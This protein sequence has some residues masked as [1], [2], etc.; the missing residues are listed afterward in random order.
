MSWSSGAWQQAEPAGIPAPMPDALFRLDG[1]RWIPH[2]LTR[3]PWAPNAMHGGPVAALMAHVLERVEAPLP[4]FP[5]RLT[6][7]L[8]RPVPIVP[9]SVETRIVRPGKKVQWAEARLAADGAEVARATLLR[10]RDAEIPWPSR[11]AGGDTAL[12]FAGP[13]SS[14][15]VRP[16]WTND[17]P[18]AYHSTAT[19]HRV[20]RGAWGEL[21]PT[22][23]WI[24]LRLPL[25]EG[26]T[27]SPLVRVAAVADF[28]NGI[29]SALPFESHRFINPD[30]TITLHRLPATEWVCLDA[31]TFPERHGV[32]VAESN[33]YD[34]RGRIGHAAQTLLLETW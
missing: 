9:L 34:E 1:D 31:V 17:Y 21:G 7:E 3:G 23:D 12:P 22:T 19:E 16:P 30:L 6:I 4:M 28:G 27:P 14:A 20:L 32:G 2:E 10:I 18:P 8:M 24:R 5:A 25:V 33:L 11:T 13:D 15:V 29:S 26:E